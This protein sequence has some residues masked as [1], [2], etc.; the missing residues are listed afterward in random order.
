MVPYL[1]MTSRKEQKKQREEKTLMDPTR[2]STSRSGILGLVFPTHGRKTRLLGP[3][4]R[5]R[6]QEPTY[7]LERGQEIVTESRYVIQDTLG[8]GGIGTVYLAT[9]ET[10]V[11]AFNRTIAT[12]HAIKII[13]PK[14]PLLQKEGGYALL[15]HLLWTEA[16]INLKLGGNPYTARVEEIVTLENGSIGLVFELIK[17]VTLRE[18]NHRHL[19]RGKLI[20]CDIAVYVVHRVASVLL[21]AQR[22][23]VCHR[24]LSD[25]NVMIHEAGPLKVLDW[26]NA[27]AILGKPGYQSPEDIDNP[28][29]V[30][31]QADGPAKS[32]VFSLGVLF[33]K[34]VVG[35]N[36]LDPPAGL[37]ESSGFDY[38]RNLDLDK[39][40][41][42]KDICQDVSEDLSDIIQ[43]CMAKRPRDRPSIEALY[44]DILGPYLYSHGF[45]LTAET[46]S[47]YLTVFDSKVKTARQI[48]LDRAGKNL[49]QMARW[50]LS[51]QKHMAA[52]DL[53]NRSFTYGDL[54][55]SFVDAFGMEPIKRGLQRL[56]KEEYD[57]AAKNA[58]SEDERKQLSE[59]CNTQLLKVGYASDDELKK[60]LDHDSSS[61]RR[62]N[63]MTYDRVIA[64]IPQF[65]MGEG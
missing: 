13:S 2:S 37:D 10:D 33:R 31:M 64:H 40:V 63:R 24:D 26:G 44:H 42:V 7:R 52:Q 59:Q 14:S 17:G 29:A 46:V 41:P 16:E 49:A 48:P 5:P 56:L 47:A 25:G 1:G 12:P 39:L 3:D 45:G 36:A 55:R 11:P 65:R 53:A 61:A 8:T 22:R 21:Q 62:L 43:S 15:E 54:A 28:E 9:R 20:P 23:D 58:F 18:F 50:R 35:S 32:D 30:D 19:A 4:D 34:L 38:R 6:A 51:R 27:S 57:E 60:H